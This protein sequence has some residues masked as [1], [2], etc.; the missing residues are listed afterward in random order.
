MLSPSPYFRHIYYVCFSSHHFPTHL[1]SML[2]PRHVF[3][4]IYLVCFLFTLLTAI[5]SKYAFSSLYFPPHLLCCT[6][7][8]FVLLSIFHGSP[9]SSTTLDFLLSAFSCYLFQLYLRLVFFSF[10]S[11]SLWMSGEHKKK[12]DDVWKYVYYMIKTTS[13]LQCARSFSQTVEYDPAV[14]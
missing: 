3:H 4:L 13:H 2:S 11:L 6:Y 1:Q 12:A 8:F 9:P 10:L 14:L 5:Y 7:A